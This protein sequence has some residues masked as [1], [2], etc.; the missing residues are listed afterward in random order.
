MFALPD[1]ARPIGAG[2]VRRTFVKEAD[3]KDTRRR[4]FT[5]TEELFQAFS[6]SSYAR[7]TDLL[8]FGHTFCLNL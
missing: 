2:G 6:W 5:I 4:L 7:I 1:P 3:E 8:A